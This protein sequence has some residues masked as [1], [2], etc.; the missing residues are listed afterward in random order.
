MLLLSTV[1]LLGWPKPTPPVRHVAQLPAFSNVSAKT[2]SMAPYI[3]GGTD[4]LLLIDYTNQPL[5][6]GMVVVFDRG[7]APRTVHMIAEVY[8]DYVYMSGLNNRRS[9]GWFHR[10]KVRQIVTAVLT[11]RK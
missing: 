10:S 2:N 5:A 11:I 7:D 3:V 4:Y 9:D 1:L 8:G 6:P